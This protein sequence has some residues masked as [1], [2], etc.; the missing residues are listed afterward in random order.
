M[1]GSKRKLASDATIHGDSEENSKAHKPKHI[2]SKHLLAL[3]DAS[4]QFV[5]AHCHQSLH[6]RQKFWQCRYIVCKD[7]FL[8]N[9]YSYSY[10]VQSCMSSMNTVKK[11]KKRKKED[12]GK[13]EKKGNE[14][15][16]RKK[17][18]KTPK[19]K[20][21]QKKKN[22]KKGKERKKKKRRGRGK[23]KGR[24]GGGLLHLSPSWPSKV[25]ADQP[26]YPTGWSIKRRER[27]QE[28]Y[29]HT[30]PPIDQV[31]LTSES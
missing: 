29:S 24:R 20:Q 22:K 16:G 11:W 31:R 13:E 2:N 1:T 6:W 12:R 15:K 23:G 28:G 30:S 14:E 5:V 17:W 9:D 4:D 25:G 8:K 18:K 26:V 3:I 21:K 27:D 7:P 19:T 10:N